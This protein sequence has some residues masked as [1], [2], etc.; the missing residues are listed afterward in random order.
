MFP[1]QFRIVEINEGTLLSFSVD[2]EGIFLF[3]DPFEIAI[4]WPWVRA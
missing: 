3:I 2:K 4:V 1:L